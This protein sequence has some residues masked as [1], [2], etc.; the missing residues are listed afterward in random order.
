M[1]AV[2][3]VKTYSLTAMSE[4]S[5]ITRLKSRDRK[6]NAAALINDRWR[7]RA[8]IEVENPKGQLFDERVV[9]EDPR[10]YSPP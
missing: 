9:A 3:P 6:A 10:R 7:K 8:G 2:W 1:C 4:T 5:P